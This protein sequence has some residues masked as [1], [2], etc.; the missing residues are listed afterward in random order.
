M[1]FKDVMQVGNGEKTSFFPE[2]SWVDIGTL[3]S[4]TEISK[5]IQPL[6]WKANSSKMHVGDT[7]IVA[8]NLGND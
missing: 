2:D 3:G 6:L 5:T 4:C 7:F 8:G 1:E